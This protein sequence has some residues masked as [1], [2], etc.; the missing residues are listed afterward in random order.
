MAGAKD[1]VAVSIPFTAG[2]V[3]AALWRPGVES[4]FKWALACSLC[5]GLLFAVSCRRRKASA[6]IYALYFFIGVSFFLTSCLPGAAP[7]REMPFRLERL[8]SLI[9]STGYRHRETGALVEAP[10]TG[11]KQGLSPEIAGWFRASGASHI[12][13]LSGL[14]LGVIYAIVSRVLVVFGNGRVTL[15]ARSILTTA[16]SGAYAMMTGARPSIMRAFLFISLGEL[17]R[18]AYGRKKRPVAVLC[19]ALMLQLAV[20]PQT[21]N[22]PGFQLSYLAMLGIFIIYP[23]LKDF[24]P[25]GGRLDLVGR[26]W[27]SAALSISCQIFTA[28]LVWW[29]FGTFPT[30]FL[31]TNLLALPLTEALMAISVLTLCLHAAGICPEALKTLNDCTAGALLD[32]LR[33]ISTM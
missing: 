23:R 13:A 2:V 22:S 9:E 29:R 17:S 15:W 4:C 31:L 14:H 1:I 24:H 16:F 26:I 30:Y 3:V 6:A 12:L 32:C 21:I 5:S 20:N 7:G 19:A 33:V 8:C 25:A 18:L 10:I 27:N 28:P 11:R